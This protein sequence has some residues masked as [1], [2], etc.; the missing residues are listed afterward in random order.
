MI[1]VISL[2]DDT[3]FDALVEL[4]R[5]RL[6][7][8]AKVWTDYNFTDPGMTLIDLAAFIADTQVYSLARNRRDE[9]IAMAGLLGVHPRGAEPATG[10]LYPPELND[11]KTRYRR[12]EK[13]TRLSPIRASAPRLRVVNAIDMLPLTVQ[14]VVTESPAGSVDHTAAN[15]RPRASFAPFGAPTDLNSALRITLKRI[16]DATPPNQKEV[17]LALGFT[18]EA[19]SEPDDRLGGVAVFY[20]SADAEEHPLE[21]ILDTTSGLQRNGVIIVELAVARVASLHNI[22]LRPT[23]AGALLPRLVRVAVNALPVDQ[24][25]TVRIAKGEFGN[26]RAGQTLELGP[27]GLLD[28][29]DREDGAVWRLTDLTS[30]INPAGKPA[31]NPVLKVGTMVWQQRDPDTTDPDA[32]VY[33]LTEERNGSRITFRFGNG[34]NGSRLKPHD[35]LDI[36]LTLSRGAAG[37]VRSRLNWALENHDLTWTNT[38]PIRGGKNPLDPEDMLDE[39]RARLRAR[40]P[41]ATSGDI[42]DAVRELPAAYAVAR[43]EVEEGWERGRRTPASPRTRTLV[44]SRR[45]IDGVAT[46]SAAWTRAIRRRIAPRLDLGERLIVVAPHYRNA[47]VQ[48]TIVVATG[49]KP[50]TV[51]KAVRDDLL[52]RLRPVGERGKSWPLGREVSAT[53]ISGWIR[54]VPGVARVKTLAFLDDAGRPVDEGILKL[55]RGEL[56]YLAEAEIEAQTSGAQS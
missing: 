10:T 33:A 2:L 3:E 51:A 7:S 26:G 39:A 52:D 4:A 29:Q 37:N 14:A 12:I 47:S 15:D 35:S 42:E 30:P 21:P 31:K 20:R 11:P 27:S 48:A 17:K 49:L 5:S 50:E 8:Q 32:Q 24:Q 25:V 43:A 36:E 19:D 16:P 18:V 56:P 9:R 28:E 53:T 46:K 54:R 45:A 23:G 44:V 13:G 6:P 55:K 1:P 38:R 40:R 34:I 41:L 22:I